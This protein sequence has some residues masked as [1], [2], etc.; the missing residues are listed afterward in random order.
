MIISF[1]IKN[2]RSVKDK[3]TLSFEP[4]SS[5]DLEDYYITEPIPGLRLLK[6]GLI[7]GPNGSGKTTI[8]KGLDFLRSLI[9]D[10]SLQKQELLEFS[11]FLFDE[12]SPTQ[13]SGFELTFVHEK[14]KYYYEL[15]FTK[16]AIVYER[17]D[18]YAPKKALVY[19]RR[20]CTGSKYTVEQYCVSRVFKN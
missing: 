12:Q 5:K 13:E 14:V 19:E 4:E 18:F 9:L 1:S 16:E 8:L 2:F 7:Y 17:L 3:V 10:A 6:L 15:T 11:P 20:S